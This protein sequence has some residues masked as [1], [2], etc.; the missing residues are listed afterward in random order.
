MSGFVASSFSAEWLCKSTPFRAV[1]SDGVFCVLY[2]GSVIG[3][4][5][6]VLMRPPIVHRTARAY[7]TEAVIVPRVAHNSML[8]LAWRETAAAVLAAVR[9]I[10][11]MSVAS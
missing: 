5:L 10:Q 4:E 2:H 11:S 1:T 9:A 8:D 3:G 6:D 7:G